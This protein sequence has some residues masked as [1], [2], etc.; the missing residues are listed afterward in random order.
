[1][2]KGREL[3]FITP[4]ADTE[5]GASE[6]RAAS[7][8]GT[9]SR[10]RCPAS[11][12]LC[13]IPGRLESFLSGPGAGCGP[14]GPAQPSAHRAAPAP[15]PGPTRP[16]PLAGSSPC[17]PW[18][19]ASAAPAPRV[20]PRHL[21]PGAAA[22]PTEGSYESRG[23]GCGTGPCEPAAARCRAERTP[24]GSR[25][26]GR[27]D[28]AAVGAAGKGFRGGEQGFVSLP[29]APGRAVSCTA[30]CGTSSGR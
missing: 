5:Q 20:L 19:L 30:S 29:P 14:A 4:G 11:A 16:A 7:S 27:G 12:R 21:C 17:R 26:P 2:G 24:R 23:G 1:M 6:P 13:Q 8:E 3:S 18:T 28:R 9:R 15:G 10:R 25:S 22:A